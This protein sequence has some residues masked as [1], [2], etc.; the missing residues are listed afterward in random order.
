[1]IGKEFGQRQTYF[2]DRQSCLLSPHSNF[3]LSMILRKLARW[4]KIVPWLLQ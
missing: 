3:C 2:L 4:G 1:M